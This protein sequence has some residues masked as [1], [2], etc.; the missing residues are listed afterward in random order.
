MVMSSTPNI[1]EAIERVACFH[2][3][4]AHEDSTNE[5]RLYFARTAVA[6]LERL[7]NEGNMAGM[8]R[9]EI[10]VSD[11]L[12]DETVIHIRIVGEPDGS[13]AVLCWDPNAE[14]A[15]WVSVAEDLSYEEVEPSEGMEE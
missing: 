11:S 2:M 13:N 6:C 15:P 1:R 10:T 4:L 7:E 14:S 3:K 8:D 9:A 5:L 12:Y